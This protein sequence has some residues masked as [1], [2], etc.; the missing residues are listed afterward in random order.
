VIILDVPYDS[1]QLMAK[2]K[3][4]LDSRAME[5]LMDSRT[6][7]A[8]KVKKQELLSPRKV[9]NADSSQNAAGMLTHY[10]ELWVR[11]GNKE[12]VQTFFI[13]NLGMDHIILGY[14]WFRDFNPQIDWA[15]RVLHGPPLNFEA[16]WY[17]WMCRRQKNLTINWI[18]TSPQYKEGDKIIVVA[19]TNIAQQWAQEAQKGQKKE[20]ELPPQY[21]RWEHVFSEECTKHFPPA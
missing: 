20:Q 4:L 6:A 14:P 13:T 2:V 19:R 15:K 12:Q 11:Q 21:W 5:N 9:M 3:T 8:L 18:T 10:C 17:K 16:K 7:D 1:M